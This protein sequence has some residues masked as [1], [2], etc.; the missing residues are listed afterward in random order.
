MPRRAALHLL[1]CLLGLITAV[2]L[3]VAGVTLSDG[4]IDAPA[5]TRPAANAALVRRFYAAV[6]LAVRDG[7]LSAIDA[8]VGR[9]FRGPV[10]PGAAA[11]RDDLKR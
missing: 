2:A 9:D 3:L 11:T 6:N 10:R 1:T 4:R 7:D 5:D 8:V